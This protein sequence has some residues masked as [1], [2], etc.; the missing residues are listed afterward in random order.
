VFEAIFGRDLDR[1]TCAR[2]GRLG[3]NALNLYG[4]S[5]VPSGLTFFLFLSRH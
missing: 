4:L 1:G 2:P 5:V 3:R